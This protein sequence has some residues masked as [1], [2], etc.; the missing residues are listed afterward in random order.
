MVKILNFV[1]IPH[2]ILN[3]LP[4]FLYFIKVF[5]AAGP[6]HFTVSPEL[7]FCILSF[8]LGYSK[9]ILI[10]NKV[11]YFKHFSNNNLDYVT[12]LFYNSGNKKEWVNSIW[13]IISILTGCNLFIQYLKNRK[14]L[15][16]KLEY[17]KIFF[18]ETPFAKM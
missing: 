1:L 13:T 7:P 6:Q 9:D 5:F 8:F 3:Y 16:K 18:F 14:I 17:L 12:Q 15:L 2:T 11:I 4:V 10:S